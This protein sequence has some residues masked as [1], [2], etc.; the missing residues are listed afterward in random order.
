MVMTEDCFLSEKPQRFLGGCLQHSMMCITAD[1][2]L[3]I[4]TG[5]Y[6]LLCFPPLKLDAS[7]VETRI[8]LLFHNGQQCV[9]SFYL[10]HYN[11]I[12]CSKTEDGSEAF[13][14]ILIFVYVHC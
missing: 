12:H 7:Q 10:N 14:Q 8:K 11:F 9:C 1:R 2:E 6:N 5:K 4:V 13:A 3:V